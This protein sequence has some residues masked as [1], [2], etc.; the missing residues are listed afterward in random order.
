[1]IP[2]PANRQKTACLCRRRGLN[3]QAARIGRKR[4]R[5]RCTDLLEKMDFR[6]DGLIARQRFVSADSLPSF[7]VVSSTGSRTSNEH[8]AGEFELCGASAVIPMPITTAQRS[9]PRMLRRMRAFSLVKR[10]GGAKVTHAGFGGYAQ[11]GFSHAFCPQTQLDVNGAAR[12][13]SACSALRKAPPALPSR[14]LPSAAGL[15]FS[16]F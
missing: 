5:R 15:I 3:V 12:K 6:L 10:M 1:M 4:Q 2:S 13:E 7:T 16:C 9:N 14:R 8:S 11:P